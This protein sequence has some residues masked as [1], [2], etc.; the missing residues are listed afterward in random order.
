[1]NTPYAFHMRQHAR[2]NSA[3]VSLQKR[4]IRSRSRRPP[5]LRRL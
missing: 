4:L 2:C 1:M 3:Q 5:L